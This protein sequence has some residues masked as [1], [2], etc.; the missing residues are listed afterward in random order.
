MRNTRSSLL[1]LG[2]A[3]FLGL[4]ASGLQAAEPLMLQKIMKDLGRNMQTITDGISREDWALIEK[5]AHLI[6]NH[7]QTALSEKVRIMGFAGTSMTKYKAYDSETHEAA[8]GLGKAAKSK[9]G[10]GVINSFQKLQSACFNCHREF[11]K[12]FVEHFYGQQ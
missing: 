12:P 7:P 1:N 3:A 4:A 10:A 8:H 11:R 6:A 5:Q 2:L 9:D